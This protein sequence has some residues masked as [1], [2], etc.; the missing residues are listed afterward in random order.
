[1]APV[2]D[3]KEPLITLHVYGAVP[4]DTVNVPLVSGAIVLIVGAMLIGVEA[5][6][7]AVDLNVTIASPET[8]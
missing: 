4:P 1:V 6:V 5:G 7:E 8:E 2:T 3:P